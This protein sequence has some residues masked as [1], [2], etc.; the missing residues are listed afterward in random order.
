MIV[1]TG[2]RGFVGSN[3]VKKL[4]NEGFANL[5]LVDELEN[6][7]KDINLKN[8]KY[9]LLLDRNEFIDWLKQNATNVNFVF[10]FGA[11]TDTTET[12][13]RIFDELNFNYSIDVFKLCTLHHIP[14]IYAS[15]AATYGNGEL[16][17]NDELSI[18]NLDP[19]NEY[20]WSKQNFDLWVEKQTNTP[21]F[22]AGLKFFNVYG[23]N[24]THKGRMAS[25]IYHAYHQINKTG[26]MKL[27]KSHHPNFKD[28]EQKRD[29]I[30]VN[31]L[32]NICFF[33]F[34]NQ[35][36]NGLYNVGTG[37]A[38]SFNDLAKCVFKSLDVKE[39]IS[40]IPTPEDIR[41]KYQYF[42]EATTHKLRLAGYKEKFYTLEEGVSEYV[43]WLKKS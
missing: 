31:D 17:Y 6:K 11:R 40:Y 18:K 24:E 20:G 34:K 28:G 19:L 37:T 41:D 16:G 27:F 3:L 2:A 42:T 39:N 29:F 33:L 13:K 26:G 8:T 7:A 30:F 14:L 35:P 15:S 5:I 12:Q 21:P 25:V 38:R 22:W 23:P 1:I 32:L 10:H 9:N 4:N 43:D 36:K